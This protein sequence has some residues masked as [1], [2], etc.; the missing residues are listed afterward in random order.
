MNSVVMGSAVADVLS[1]VPC[2]VPDGLSG[3]VAC[4]APEA[5]AVLGVESPVTSLLK[6][7]WTHT[8]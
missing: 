5:L 2:H 1:A 3:L 7:G 8:S 4:I 6:E